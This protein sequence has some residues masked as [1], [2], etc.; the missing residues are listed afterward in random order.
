[1]YDNTTLNDLELD[2]GTAI[3]SDLTGQH[4]TRNQQPVRL[5][6]QTRH[7]AECYYRA[8]DQGKPYVQDHQNNKRYYPITAYCLIHDVD[9]A[10]ALSDLGRQ[11]GIEKPPG[12]W[13]PCPRLAPEPNNPPRQP[14]HLPIDV[15]ERCRTHFHRNGLYEY[16]RFT[17][18][19]VE[20][21]AAF[22]WY[23]LGTSRRWQYYGYLATCLPQFDTAG[24][25]RQVKITP[26][27]AMSGRR[28]KKHQQARQ[29]NPQ[30]RAYEPTKPD[31][32]K[33][34]FAGKQIAKDA[35]MIDVHLQQCFFGEHLLSQFLDQSVAV[36]EGESTA[37]VCSL[38]WPQ[39]IWLATGGSVGGSWYSP[40]RFSVLRGRNV[41]LWPDTGKFTD[42]SQ[43]AES[44]RAMV[45]SLRV[46]DYLEKNTSADMGNVDLRDLLTRPCYFSNDESQ[47]TYGEPLPVK[48]C[49]YYPPEWDPVNTNE[50]PMLAINLSRP[51]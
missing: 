44:L 10:T 6:D 23:R 38:L 19:Q 7:T 31:V 24:N 20:A 51:L 33:T 15:Y 50:S 36:V 34:Y 12:N 49:D 48:S 9:Y 47:P 11:Y 18:G 46:S 43:K 40:E 39:Y 2:H 25:L 16:L 8:D 37:I 27:D 45:H 21:D 41:T 3:L 32:D 13:R 28:V 26:F 1:M 29:W 30:R 4:L 35:G 17:F 22:N 5:F 42:W 14:N